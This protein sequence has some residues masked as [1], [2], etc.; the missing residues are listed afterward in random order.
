M[1][2]I[3]P[4]IPP[5]GTSLADAINALTQQLNQR[6]ARAEA[7]RNRSALVKSMDRLGNDFR[8]FSNPFT[9]LRDSFT[10]LDKTNRDALKIGV[11]NEKLSKAVSENS[12]I[13]SRGLVSDAKLQQAIIQNFGEGVRFQGEGLRALTE[14]MIATGQDTKALTK[15]NSDLVLFTGNNS[16][17]INNLS[18]VNK[19]VSDK[20]GVSNDKLVQTMNSLRDTL[21]QASFFGTN[22]VESLGEAAQFFTGRAG[23]TDIRGALGTLNRILVG[24]FETV[25][26]GAI[27]GAGGAR[28]SLAQGRRVSTEEVIAILSNLEQRRQALGGGEFGLDILSQ[29]LGLGKSQVTEL[30]NLYKI[31][32]EDFKL[33]EE[34]KKTNDET[35]NNIQNINERARNFYD[36]T[37]MLML[38]QLGSINTNLLANV[39]KGAMAAGALGALGGGRQAGVGSRIAG[40]AGGA[41]LAGTVAAGSFGVGAGLQGTMQGVSLGAAVGSVVPVLGTAVGAALGLVAGGLYD[42]TQY[43]KTSAESDAERL[44]MEREKRNQER[45]AAA[46]DDIRRAQFV[47]G[48]LRSKGGAKLDEHAEI[49]RELLDEIRKQTT[50]GQRDSLKADR[51]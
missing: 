24:G 42:L 23:G 25:Q 9:R 10:R 17:A 15:L 22:A 37:A 27:L 16:K 13:L 28:Q 29:Q 34:I 40:F 46:T 45:A 26:A 11:T 18:R 19:E 36:S 39:G 1:T 6:E 48:Y 35:F 3:P 30:L 31:S 14:E 47:I 32:Q 8:S 51:P 33:N 5:T 20:Y 7:E 2:G 38:G 49:L 43:A 50:N 21:Q 4:P 12:N 41:A 44:K